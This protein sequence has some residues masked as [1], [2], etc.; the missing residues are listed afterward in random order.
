MPF[1][2]DK[3]V[4]KIKSTNNKVLDMKININPQAIHKRPVPQMGNG[5]V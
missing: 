3:T 1:S 2:V 4:D 5:S